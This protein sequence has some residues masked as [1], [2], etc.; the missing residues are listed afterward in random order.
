MLIRA[1]LN[2]SVV[3]FV[4]FDLAAVF[5]SQWRSQSHGQLISAKE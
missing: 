2:N 4:I 1:V 3:I 5:L